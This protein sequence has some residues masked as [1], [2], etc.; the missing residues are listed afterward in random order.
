[1]KHTLSIILLIAALNGAASAATPHTSDTLSINGGQGTFT[2]STDTGTVKASFT[3]TRGNDKSF[4]GDTVKSGKAGGAV[5]A[6]HKSYVNADGAVHKATNTELT[7][8]DENGTTTSATYVSSGIHGDLITGNKT[9]N[10]LSGATISSMLVG[11]SIYDTSYVYTSKPAGLTSVKGGSFSFNPSTTSSVITV[12]VSGGTIGTIVGGNWVA[13]SAV[14]ASSDATTGYTAFVQNEAICINISGATTNVR[15]VCGAMYGAVNNTITI[16]ISD[17][18]TISNALYGGT[19]GYYNGSTSTN[20]YTK[21][22][23]IKV[24]G[25]NTKINCDIF[26]GGQG[27]SDNNGDYADNARADVKGST[28]IEITGGTITGNIYGG[29][30][31]GDVSNDAS[32][33]LTGGSITGN[34]YGGGKEGSVKN[35]KVTLD[36]ADVDGNIYGGGSDG[37]TVT[38]TATVELLSG[39]VTGTVYAGG[40]DATST[41]QGDTIL[42]VGNE[43]K[44]YKGSVGDISGFKELYIQEGSSLTLN[45]GNAFTIKE[46]S[47]ILSQKNL[48][49]AALTCASAEITDQ[50]T[51]NIGFEGTLVSGQY[52]II[53]SDSPVQG[54]SEDKVTLTGIAGFEDL[55]WSG[56]TLYFVYRSIDMDAMTTA[57]W[58]VFK[59]SQAFTNT[60]WTPRAAESSID[61]PGAKNCRAWG[62]LYGH[63]SRIGSNG[64]DYSLQG[65]A[66]G[67]EKGL[68][69]TRSIGIALGY[70]WGKVKPATAPSVDQESF[71]LAGYGRAWQTSLNNRDTVA[72]DW[73]AALGRTTSK[74]RLLAE[75]WTQN[76]VQLDARATYYRYLNGRTTISGFAGAQ[77]YAQ[78]SDS[79]GSY[80]A[81]AMQNLRISLGGGLTYELTQRTV[82]YGE[83]SLHQDIERHNPS[84]AA[85]GAQFS[86]TNPG[87]FGGTLSAGIEH[88]LNDKWNVHA[89]YSFSTADDQNEHNLNAGASYKF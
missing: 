70:D 7:I 73:S 33:K 22:T 61:L 35:T 12:N 14:N 34:V 10:V 1:M 3:G 48:S 54:W 19:V 11:G 79:V 53:A 85:N 87:R 26:G 37:G 17:G 89:N 83:V 56:N 46:H 75:D 88:M 64:A 86:C 27:D 31:N 4:C 78:D 18:A 29:S 21:S 25:K 2:F 57:N 36:G 84:V 15:A 47:I 44:N 58:G 69:D 16:D 50:I 28:S 38:E 20:T 41:V 23:S 49:E 77:Y 60:L 66:I 45:T 62:S 82:L 52:K 65:G 51:L 74:H 81:K 9:I 24:S 30:E 59:S 76:N 40:A 72:I 5:A 6:L 80:K 63:S 42:R 68:S 39:N 55:T 43:T 8:G 13:S 32:I 71:H 67:M